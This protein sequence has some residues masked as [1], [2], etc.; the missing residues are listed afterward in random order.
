[1]AIGAFVRIVLA[2][3]YGTFLGWVTRVD[4]GGIAAEGRWVREDGSMFQEQN[5]SRPWEHIAS[6]SRAVVS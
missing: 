3:D 1:M 5:L 4:G 2:G 6:I